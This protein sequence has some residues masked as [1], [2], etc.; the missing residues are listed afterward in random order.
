M[1]GPKLAALCK[2]TW[3]ATRTGVRRCNYQL[4]LSSLSQLNFSTAP[5]NSLS[6]NSIFA[7]CCNT[8]FFHKLASLRN[9]VGK[10]IKIYTFPFIL[11]V[12]NYIY[13]SKTHTARI[14]SITRVPSSSFS[15]TQVW[16]SFSFSLL[17][18]IFFFSVSHACDLSES[19]VYEGR[20]LGFLYFHAGNYFPRN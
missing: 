1:G 6:F 7:P 16:T 2:G 3:A 9:I 19:S 17:V 4:L 15:D 20:Q 5:N 11:A 13:P 8:F 10:I 18:F 12:F 14:S